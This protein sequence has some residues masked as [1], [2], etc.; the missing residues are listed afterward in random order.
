MGAYN[1]LR[2]LS[3][4]IGFTETEIKVLLFLAVCLLAGFAIKFIKNE[5]IPAYK[6]YDYSEQDSLFSY[7]TSQAEKH[8]ETEK[9]KNRVDSKQEVL[10][11]KPRNFE[12]KVTPEPLVEKS[13]NINTASKEMLLKL[14]GI[15]EKTAQNIID[16]RA[17]KG[18][19]KSLEE[20]LDVKGIGTS[21]FNKIKKFL[22]IE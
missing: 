13:I 8:L 5:S 2:N 21:K 12:K 20:L 9:E 10:D 7:Y 19:F 3:K 15:G 18:K 22:Y 1:M 17:E 4:K 16:L 11:F 6:K 14:P